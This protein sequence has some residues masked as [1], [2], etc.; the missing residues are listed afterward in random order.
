MQFPGVP[1]AYN[2]L[3]ENH[4]ADYKNNAQ[5]ER[6]LFANVDLGLTNSDDCI[7][8]ELL[9]QLTRYQKATFFDQE[10]EVYSRI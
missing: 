7:A 8:Q 9:Y 2:T 3:R 6:P 10:R 1:R 5:D 4:H